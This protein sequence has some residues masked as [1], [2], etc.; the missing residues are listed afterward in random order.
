[1]EERGP[2]ERRV[3]HIQGTTEFVCVAMKL[4]QAYDI[5]VAILHEAPDDGKWLFSLKRP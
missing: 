5:A 1:M 3:W 2:A 4:K